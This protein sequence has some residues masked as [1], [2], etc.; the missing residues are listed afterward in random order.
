MNAIE[1][2]RAVDHAAGMN[3]RWLFIASLMVIGSF[4]MWVMRYFVKQHERLINDHKSS[5]ECY[6]TSLR[7]VVSEQSAANAK[8]VVCLDNNSKILEE[9]R[10][11]LR[12]SRRKNNK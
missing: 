2:M 3:D 10:D 11:E 8:L 5:R 12:R 9:C 4:G 6:Q 7:R 1:M